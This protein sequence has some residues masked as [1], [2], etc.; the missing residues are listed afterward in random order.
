MKSEIELALRSNPGHMWHFEGAEESAMSIVKSLEGEGFLARVVRGSECRTKSALLREFSNALEFPDYFGGN[1][2]A[3]WECMTDLDW[4][5]PTRGFVVVITE[6]GE[7]LSGS[8][9]RDLKIAIEGLVSAIDLW[10]RGASEA[11]PY[12]EQPPTPLHVIFQESTPASDSIMRRC[13]EVLPIN[14]FRELEI[15]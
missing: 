11:D 1:W 5:P 10:G 8:T 2:D 14:P 4:F 6:S 3:W 13:R 7:F 15:R 12:R 9:I